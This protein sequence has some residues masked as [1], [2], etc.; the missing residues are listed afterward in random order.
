[1]ALVY[2]LVVRS[3]DLVPLAQYAAAPGNFEP[4]AMECLVR[5]QRAGGGGQ[6]TAPANGLTYTFLAAGLYTVG[7]A[8][9]CT[10]AQLASR[11]PI[12]C[13]KRICEAWAEQCWE[14]GQYT[15]PRSLDGLFG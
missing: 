6:F 4:E 5:A 14:R 7:V 3:A 10:K 13:C 2:A 12:T 11:A 8:A 1:M 15:A 9:D